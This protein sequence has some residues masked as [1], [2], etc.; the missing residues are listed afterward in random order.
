MKW[1]NTRIRLQVIFRILNVQF[2]SV[3]LIT[4]DLIT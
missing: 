2:R 4:Y 3:L 1:H